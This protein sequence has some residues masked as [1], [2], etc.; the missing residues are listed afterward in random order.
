LDV[1]FEKLNTLHTK[2]MI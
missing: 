1:S 2:Q